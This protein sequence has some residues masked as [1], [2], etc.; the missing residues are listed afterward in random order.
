M[1]SDNGFLEDFGCLRSRRGVDLEETSR[2]REE[3][4]RVA[5]GGLHVRVRTLG[6][7]FDAHGSREGFEFCARYLDGERRKVLRRER[8]MQRDLVA[9]KSRQEVWSVT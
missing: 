5:Q 7:A 8:M 9:S 3:G 1:R 2:Q 4:V 6:R